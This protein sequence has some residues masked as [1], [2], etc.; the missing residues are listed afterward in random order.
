M[1][2]YSVS[3]LGTGFIGLCS[4]ACFA[5]KDIKV[6][7]STHNEKKANLINNWKAPFYE[8]NLQEIMDEIK[9]EKPELLHC[10]LD[11]VQAV[12]DTDISMITQ[13]TPMRADKSINLEYIESTAREIGEAL[14]TKDKYHL[15]VVRSTVVPGTSRNLVGK[16]I[17]EVSGKQPG[18]D[19]G[20]CMQPEFLAEGRSIED[21]LRP[22]RIVI[23]Q[24]DEKSGEMLQEFYEY[25][26]GDHLKECPILRMNLESAELVKYGNNCLLSTKISYANEFANFA[27]LVPNV[28][29]VQVMKGV[30]LDYRINSRFL[31]AGV[32]FG[33][34]CFH[35]DVNAIKAW[36]KSKG[37]TS[38]L[39]EAVLGINDDQ[40]IH[41]VDIAEDLAGKLSGRRVTLLGLSFKPGT[42]DMREAPSIRVVEELLKRG[43]SNIVGYDPKANE[44]AEEEMGD[45][46]E[47]APSIEEALT[48]SECAL[49]IT[50]WDEFKKLTPEDFKK[51]MKVPNV[52][53]GRRAFD[54]E[55][56]DK[57]LNFRALGRINL[58]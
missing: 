16:I 4:A 32:G 31:G 53:D 15:V 38:R 23:G 11:P 45:K 55:T 28:D 33:G 36:S 27:E 56:F 51:H 42:D 7:A 29:V 52:V 5:Q 57:E 17:S 39:L 41:I 30:G 12:L 3:I 6:I 14:K 34:S 35:K 49:L 1:Y 19:F 47:Y 48:D 58:A 13:G 54:Y 2:K 20:L 24:F 18:K 10:S 8:E 46:L 26:Y 21:T 40:A 44:T 50:E 22:D 37:Y 9:T 25:F 43:I